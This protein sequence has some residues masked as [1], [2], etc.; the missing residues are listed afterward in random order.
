MVEDMVVD[1]AR[2]FVLCVE[3]S[4]QSLTLEEGGDGQTRDDVFCFKGNGR[5]I[6][7]MVAV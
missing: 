7:W 4:L 5:N 6:Y 2:W 1:V 3:V